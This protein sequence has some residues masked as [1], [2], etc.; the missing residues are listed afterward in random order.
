ME[1]DQLKLIEI[2]VVIDALSDCIPVM[3]ED[4]TEQ[5]LTVINALEAL[6]PIA[7]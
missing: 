1:D 6:K 4:E 3:N 7:I 2:Q 5:T